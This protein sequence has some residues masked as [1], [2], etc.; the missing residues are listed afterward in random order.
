[1]EHELFNDIDKSVE[2]DQHLFLNLLNR[3]KGRKNRV[4]EPVVGKTINREPHA[5]AQAWADYFSNL[6]TPKNLARFDYEHKLFV[7]NSLR[8]M[9]T[10]SYSNN[11]NVLADDIALHEVIEAIKAGFPLTRFRAARPG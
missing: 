3:H 11:K 2:T 9:T 5:I 10:S 8:V 7:E 1:M 4:C 6:Y